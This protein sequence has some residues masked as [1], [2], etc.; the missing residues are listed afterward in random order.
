MQFKNEQE[1]ITR[2]KA[3]DESAVSIWYSSSKD[4]LLQFFLKRMSSEAD[5]QELVHDTFLS[6]LSSLPLFRGES[7]LWTFMLSVARHELADYWR[8]KYAKKAISMLPFGHEILESLSGESSVDKSEMGPILDQL[9]DEIS[10]MLQL[11]YI[12][13]KSVKELA[14]HYNLSFAA[15]QS[16]LHRAKELFKEIYERTTISWRITTEGKVTGGNW[17]KLTTP[18]VVTP[19][20]LDHR[21]ALLAIF[22]SCFICLGSSH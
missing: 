7:E 14:V 11:K 15:M 20:F 1:L 3:G 22:T 12:D 5:A 6:C 9:P 10:E 19:I 16:K 17:E 21:D 2:L 4:E 8:K 18:S 13:G